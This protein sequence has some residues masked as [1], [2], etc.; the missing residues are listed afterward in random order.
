VSEGWRLFALAPLPWVASTIALFVLMVVMHIVPIIGG[1]V[2]QV[3]QVVIWA[4]F[5][6][7]CRSLERG[8]EFEPGDL[9][10][11][12]RHHFVSL[13]VIAVI[14]FVCGLLIALLWVAIVGLQSIFVMFGGLMVAAQSGDYAML[15]DLML[16]MFRALAI[17]TLV[18]L[19][20]LVPLMA[21]MWFAPALVVM[22]GM[23][24]LAAMKASLVHA[25][26][27]TMPFL[28]YGAVMLLLAL[29]VPLTL[30]LAMLV[31]LPLVIT[32]A[33]ASYRDIF[34]EEPLAA[35]VAMAA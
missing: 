25:L 3:L 11:G 16:Q 2:F 4:G 20:L 8:G 28:V 12:F 34:T 1:M 29:L 31:Y 26:R 32:S 23:G 24:P 6:A 30:G 21:A 5:I 14:Y 15:L 35:P 19:A 10:A 33:Y 7:C 17:A 27:N 9:A 22:H 13:V 18:A